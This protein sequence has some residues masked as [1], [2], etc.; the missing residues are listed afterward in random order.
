MPV[1]NLI[2]FH[3][4]HVIVRCSQGVTCYV[5]NTIFFGAEGIC[6]ADITRISF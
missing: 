5:S 1:L 6:G 4:I 3:L 2:A